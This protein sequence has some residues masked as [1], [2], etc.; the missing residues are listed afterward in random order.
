MTQAYTRPGS[1]DVDY[2]AISGDSVTSAAQKLDNAIDDIYTQIQDGSTIVKGVLQIGTSATQAAAGNHAHTGAYA[3]AAEGVTNGNS[4]DHSGGDG[5]TIAYASISGAPTIS[6]F[7]ASLIDDSSASDARTTLGLAIGTDVQAYDAA[8]AKT[9]T[10]QAWTRQQTLTPQSISSSGGSLAIDANY[11]R[12][13][14]TL[15]E[16]TAI[17]A[18]TNAVEG[19]N[20]WI[21][22]TGASTYTWSHNAIFEASKATALPSAPAAGKTSDFFYTYH[23]SKWKLV[24]IREDA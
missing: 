19:D 3:P 7:G 16:N 23:D 13:K 2:N 22:V 21:T 24:G 9:D 5:G 11:M 1:T 10:K 20:L 15:T 14:T 6:V 12:F 17:A 18:P 8:T 4:H